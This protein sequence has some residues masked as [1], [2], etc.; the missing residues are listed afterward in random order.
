MEQ[1][2][3]HILD[4]NERKLIISSNINNAKDKIYDSY[5]VDTF[6][7]HYNVDNVGS[8][9]DSNDLR[10]ICQIEFNINTLIKCRLYQ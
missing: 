2:T 4:I 3:T 6:F 5:C 1:Y 9:G 8:N 10:E 7:R